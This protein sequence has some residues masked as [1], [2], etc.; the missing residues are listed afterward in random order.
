MMY[1]DESYGGLPSTPPKDR[2]LKVAAYIRVSTDLADQKNSYETQERYFRRLLQGN[3]DWIFAGIYSDYGISGTSGQKRTGFKRILRHCTEKKID[4]IICKSISRFARNTLDFMTAL[5]TLQESGTTI[6]F[7]EDGLDTS[8]QTSHFILT[9]LAAIAQEESRSISANIRWG[10]ERRFPRGEVRNQA[11]YGYRYT[12]SHAVSENGY[13]YRTV[14][15]VEEEAAVVRRIF[16]QAAQGS[17]CVEI[18]RDL[19]G[20]HIPVRPSPYARRRLEHASRGQ[21][22]STIDEGWTAGQIRL[23]LTNERYS[24]DV[25]IQKTCTENYLTHHSRKNRGEAPQYWARN[26]HP[27]IISRELFEGAGLMRKTGVPSE[28]TPSRRPVRYPFSQTLIC[29][30][31]G[32]FYHIRNTAR[33]PIWF[34]PSTARNNGK[35]LCHN[36]KIYEEQLIRMFRRA[37]L[38]RFRLMETCPADQLNAADIM[39]GHFTKKQGAGAVFSGAAR[40]FLPQMLAH[41][42]SIQKMDFAERDRAFLQRRLRDLSALPDDREQERELLAKQLDYMEDYWLELEKSYD[43]RAQAIRW[44]YTLPEGNDG[45]IEFLNQITGRYVKAFVLSVTVH[46]PLHYTVHWFDDSRTQVEMFSNIGDHRRTDTR[47]HPK[48]RA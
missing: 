24:G 11:I 6:Y 19:N 21:L 41:L 38:E 8:D 17:S 35:N 16:E 33:N 40:N 43:C 44:M 18:A 32:R 28:K 36:H 9:T 27:A 1:S 13:R 5:N 14:E 20:R 12:G 39:S 22:H 42:E 23:I 4:R 30:S 37:I 47:C 48:K 3:P 15:I 10:N 29:G 7:E 26:H 31:C 2:R 45:L 25:L 34:C 46:D